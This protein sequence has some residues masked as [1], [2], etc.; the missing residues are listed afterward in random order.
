MIRPVPRG[1]PVRAFRRTGVVRG[2]AAA[3]LDAR[4]PARGALR[5]GRAACNLSCPPTGGRVRWGCARRRD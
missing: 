4:S 1:S 5:G 2:R 3:L